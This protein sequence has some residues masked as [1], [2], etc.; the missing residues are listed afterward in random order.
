M[1]SSLSQAALP[2]FKTGLKALSAILGKAEAHAS[3]KKI[4]PSVL[5][6][7][8]IAPDMFTLT[9]QV[10]IATDQAKNGSGAGKT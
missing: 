2:V 5:L 9:R 6:N 1:S 3:E 7:W 4:E 10:Q 8:R